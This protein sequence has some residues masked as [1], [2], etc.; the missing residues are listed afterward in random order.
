VAYFEEVLPQ[1]LSEGSINHEEPKPK[2]PVSQLQF[3]PGPSR[4]EVRYTYTLMLQQI[5]FFY[6]N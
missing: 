3:E 1:K 2:Q 4:T 6:F 5:T